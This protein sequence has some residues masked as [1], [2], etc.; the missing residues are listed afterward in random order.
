MVFE[1]GIEERNGTNT[2]N[3]F[4]TP[5]S[6]S[7]QG[8]DFSSFSTHTY[9]TLRLCTDFYVIADLALDSIVTQ[10]M[11][12]TDFAARPPMGFTIVPTHLVTIN[13]L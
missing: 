6:S 5:S 10:Q 12:M 1:E 8:E 2:P 11:T 4:L 7:P 9:V 13:L 3:R